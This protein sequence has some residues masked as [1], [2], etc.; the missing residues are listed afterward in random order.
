MLALNRAVIRIAAGL[1]A[2]SSVSG[3]LA[4]SLV[5]RM[6]RCLV[7]FSYARISWLASF[8]RPML[9]ARMASTARE[10]REFPCFAAPTNLLNQGSKNLPLLLLGLFFNPVVAGFYTMANRLLLVSLQ[11]GVKAVRQSF[12]AEI[13]KRKNKGEKIRPLF[14]QT[15]MW[16][17]IV[18]ALPMFAVY[19]WGEPIFGL[20]LGD[21]WV[22]A[23]LY[24]GILSPWI[25][26]VFMITPASAMYVVC[27]TQPLWLKLNIG[28]TAVRILTLS[29]GYFS[30]L[31]ATVTLT[32]FSWGNVCMN[33]MIILVAYSICKNIQDQPL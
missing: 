24:A 1:W 31:P 20:F 17:G 2:G 9:S 21:K 28:V 16:I 30:G 18:G 11:P 15:T 23:G 22:A 7:L 6:S 3:L 25:L 13:A 27:R 12:L 29:L 14:I 10:Y 5:G 33:V 19:Y 26:T 8:K 32:L 4:G